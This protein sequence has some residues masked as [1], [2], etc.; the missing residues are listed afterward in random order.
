MAG[1]S[2]IQFSSRTPVSGSEQNQ[3]VGDD[4]NYVVMKTALYSAEAIQVDL[5]QN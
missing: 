2:L 5:G 1:T 3:E 4:R